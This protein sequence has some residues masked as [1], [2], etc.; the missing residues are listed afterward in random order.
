MKKLLSFVIA[1]IVLVVPARARSFRAGV[2]AAAADP[3]AVVVPR[4]VRMSWDERAAYDAGVL[5]TLQ[6]ADRKRLSMIISIP[7]ITEP[8]SVDLAITE[9]LE[10]AKQHAPLE[11]LGID[12]PAAPPEVVGYA[13]KS[14]SVQ[15]QGRNIAQRSIHVASDARQLELLTGSGAASYIDTYLVEGDRQPLVLWVQENDPSKEIAFVADARSANPLYDVAHGFKGG[16][17]VV[18]LEQPSE[19]AALAL[20]ALNQELTGDWAVDASS[21]M[22]FLNASGAPTE[23]PHVVLIR[24]EDLRTLVVPEGSTEAAQILQVAAADYEKPVIVSSG[25]ALPSSDSGVRGTHLL[26]GVARADR[27]VAI[28]LSRREPPPDLTRETIEVATQRGLSV[29]EIVRNHQ[30]YFAYQESVLP[31][32]IARNETDLRFNV[33][34]GESIEATIAGDHFF[35]LKG[36]NDWVWSDFFLNG[37]RW[38]YGRMPELPLIQPEKVTQLPLAIQF[39]D[40]YRYELVRETPLRGFDTY[41]VRFQPQSRAASETPRYRG[42]VWIDKRT[43]ARVRVQMVALNLQ[44]EVLSSEERVDYSPFTRESH[45]RLGDATSTSIPPRELLWIPTAVEAEQVLSTAGRATAVVRSTTF[46][47]FRIG[48]EQFDF[49]HAKASASQARMVR[50][51]EEGLRYLE[52]R[53]DGT[54]E[55]KAGFDTSR[56]FLVGGIYHDDGLEFPIVPLG[57]LNYFNFD[58]GGRGLQTNIFFAGVVI[59]ANLTDPSFLGTR[60]NVGADFFGIG[61]ASENKIRRNGVDI[62]EETVKS[63]PVNLWLRAGHPF[64]EF[65]KFDASLGIA[66]VSY[67]LAEETGS[68]FRVPSN[69][70]V[71]NPGI[72]A[73]Y[74]R[75][76]WTAATSIDHGIRTS[77]EP[78]G[79]AKEYDE[80]Q[81]SFTRFGARLGK[82]FYLPNFQRLG[83]EANYVDGKNLDRFSKYEFSFFGGPRIR[84]IESGSL[85]AEK[86]LLGHL[87]YGLV[88]SDQF[89]LEAFFDYGLITDKVSGFRNEPFQGVGLAG[90]TI[91]PFG[92]LL[93]IDLGKSVGTNAQD[94]FIANIVLLKMFD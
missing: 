45:E 47:D 24:G 17:T 87:S 83:L 85:R 14:L 75:W 28:S 44:G 55:V 93:R 94:G 29:E 6:P 15:S 7:Q 50:D 72:E 57:G 73:R 34:A 92:T 80:K 33:A 68:G 8:A 51:T 74:D 39:D 37:V 56:L 23:V 64:A 11:G 41:E 26:I 18:Y 19:T 81:R 52:R 27:P 31:R 60:A 54:R 91:G 3:S 61:I 53:E 65:G 36:R 78:W 88:F 42:T 62:A 35:E 82:T 89:R 21:S 9:I 40:D 77:W 10:W 66:H 90:Q 22:R 79:L 71:L 4:L 48:T 46:S 49:L 20:A 13:V 70:F 86:A 43:W 1:L 30:A 2:V 67:Q 25:G 84:G 76:G 58:L 69:T 32:Y 12:L 38:K 16:A 5:Q 63:L 59:A